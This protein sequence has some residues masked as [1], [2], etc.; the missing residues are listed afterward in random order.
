MADNLGDIYEQPTNI[1]P[2]VK[3]PCNECP[4]R[5]DAA[6]GHL[7][8][9]SAMEWH[10]IAHGESA[11]A[12]HKTIRVSGEWAPGTRQCRGAAIF[13]ENVCKNPRNPTIE[14]GPRD[15]ETVFATDEEFI[16]H[17]EGELGLDEFYAEHPW[18][19]PNDRQEKAKS[20]RRQGSSGS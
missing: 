20:R 7:G 5:R 18:L 11:I 16:E 4:W 12:C 8:P 9:H 3:D 2:A 17:H 6:P 13:R 19:E 15:M 1:P 10:R 14:T